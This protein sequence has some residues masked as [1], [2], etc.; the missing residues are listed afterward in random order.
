M[1]KPIKEAK[2]SKRDKEANIITDIVNESL[3]YEYEYDKEDNWIIFGLGII[4]NYNNKWFISI[5]HSE[6]NNRIDNISLLGIMYEL[7]LHK[8][9]VKPDLGYISVY[10]NKKHKGILLQQDIYDYAKNNNISEME[11]EKALKKIFLSKQKTL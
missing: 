5:D 4:Y 7:T 1:N 2:L 6:L 10:K 8:I 11:A 3:C 9:I